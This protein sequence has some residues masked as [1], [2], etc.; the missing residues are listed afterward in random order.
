[1][2]TSLLKNTRALSYFIA[3]VLLLAAG[4]AGVSA[5]VDK[6]KDSDGYLGI[7]MQKLTRD[8]ARGLDIGAKRGVLI[9][10]VEDDSPADKAGIEDGDVIVEFDGRKVDSPDE[11]R[12]MVEDAAVGEKVKIKLIR[13]G[14]EKTIE[15]VVGERPERLAWTFDNDDDFFVDLKDGF[16]GAL[17]GVWPGPRL[18]VQ[19]A[20]L[21]K[22]LASYFDTEAGSGVLVLNVEDESV[23]EEAGIK[24]G[25]VIQKVD[26][27]DVTSVDDLRRSVRDFE[28]GDEFDVVVVRHGKKETLK[29][30]M[31]EQSGFRVLRGGDFQFDRNDLPLKKFKK[32]D[33]GRVLIYSDEAKDEMKDE[34][35]ALR[36]EL[37]ELKQELKKLKKD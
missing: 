13:D 23:A 9:N 35:K 22:D 34:V 5:G 4:V 32:F 28:K 17:A 33:D 14:D 30:T 26:D 16:H 31:D 3:V 10:G 7:Y 6:D 1:M 27:E 24:A 8:V 18:G 11:L 36:K 2:K 20:E 25:D 12:E 37:E 21:N 19:A 15:V 29:A